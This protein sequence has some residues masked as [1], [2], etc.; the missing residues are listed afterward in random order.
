MLGL[1]DDYVMCILH[2]FPT[3]ILKQVQDDPVLVTTERQFE[4]TYASNIQD[5]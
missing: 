4:N 2:L 5:E 1:V 3:K